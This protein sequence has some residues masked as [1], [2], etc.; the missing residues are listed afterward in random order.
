MAIVRQELMPAAGHPAGYIRL[1][2][3]GKCARC[4]RAQIILEDARRTPA[5]GFNLESAAARAGWVCLAD[6][7]LCPQCS[8]L[9]RGAADPVEAE[10]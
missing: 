6:G 4:H 5:F 8:R 9:S 7:W 1:Q 10:E 3:T 2:M